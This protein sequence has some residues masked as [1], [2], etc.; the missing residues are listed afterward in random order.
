MKSL[1][2]GESVWLGLGEFTNPVDHDET[3]QEARRLFL[4]ALQELAPQVLIDLAS[5]PLTLYRPLWELSVAAL[6]EKQRREWQFHFKWSGVLSWTR[7]KNVEE[8]TNPEAAAFRDRLI[9]WARQ[10]NLDASDDDWI[11][12]HALETLLGWCTFPGL[13]KRDGPT[14][15]EDARSIALELTC[16]EHEITF[17]KFAWDPQWERKGEARRRIR[18]DINQLLTKHL[19]RIQEIAEARL[20]ET[21]E[22]KSGDA[23]FRWLILFQVLDLEWTEVAKRVGRKDSKRVRRDALAIAKIVG[24][25]PR[26]GR[27]VGRPRTRPLN[28]SRPRQGTGSKIVRRTR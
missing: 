16:A 10:W 22:L 19:D 4:A 18:D 1:P 21:R 5:E 27:G 23:H 6:S 15:A 28:E 9:R 26:T 24:I 12:D 14:W 17:P 13:F 25:T 20:I 3:C 7:L 2:K 11:M 8:S